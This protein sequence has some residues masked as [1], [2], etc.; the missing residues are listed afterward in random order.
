M[1]THDNKMDFSIDARKE[2]EILF[3]KVME[4]YLGARHIFETEDLTEKDLVFTIHDEIDSL[5]EDFQIS[6]VN[7]VRN[8]VSSTQSEIVFLDAL[9]N[10]ERI[11]NHSK[12]IV[13]SVE[14][15]SL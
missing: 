6:H 12:N 4:I 5:S 15:L 7:R 13:Q 9:G 11:G 2:L 10:L 8:Q 14:R 1:V 3:E